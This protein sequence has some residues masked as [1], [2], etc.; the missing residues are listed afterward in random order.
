MLFTFK[1]ASIGNLIMHEKSGK[2]MLVLLGKNPEDQRGIIT[3]DQLSSAI[4]T[5]QAAVSAEKAMMSQTAPQTNEN[6]H[7]D[8]QTISLSQRAVPFIE[9]LER[10]LGDKEPVIWGV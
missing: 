4:S 5:L 7:S 10:A 3:V 2:E 6:K 9:M 8:N 1:S